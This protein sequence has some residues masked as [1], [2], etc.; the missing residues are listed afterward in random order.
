MTIIS[1]ATPSKDGQF[2]LNALQRA[3]NKALKRKKESGQYAVVWQEGKSVLI[4]GSRLLYLE[5]GSKKM[6]RSGSRSR[7]MKNR[8]KSKP[9]LMS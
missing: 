3:V 5:S 8:R 9:E 6:S 4:T 7:K 2:A 1:K